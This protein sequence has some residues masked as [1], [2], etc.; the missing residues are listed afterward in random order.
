MKKLLFSLATILSLGFMVNSCD[1]AEFPETVTVSQDFITHAAEVSFTTDVSGANA[2]ATF[3]DLDNTNVRVSGP[4]AALIYNIDGVKSFIISG[5]KLQLILDPSANFTGGKEFKVNLEIVAAGYLKKIVPVTFTKEATASAYTVSMTKLSSLP[6]GVAVTTNNA[7]Q[8]V[9]AGLTAPVTVVS[10]VASNVDVTTTTV[11][12]PTGTVMRDANNTVL[13][14][15]LK[16]EVVSFTAKDDVTASFPGGLL[17]ENVVV[18]GNTPE[19]GLF[20]PVGFAS[21]EMTVGGQRVKAFTG[22]KVTLKMNLPKDSNNPAT[23]RPYAVGE[24]IDVFSYDTVSGQWKFEATAKVQ[25]ES[26]ESLFASYEATHL[27]WWAFG[28]FTRNS[29]CSSR[30]LTFN[31]PSTVPTLNVTLMI[32][33]RVGA[34]GSVY[35]F[36]M[37]SDINV[38]KNQTVTL[39]RLLTN[40][41]GRIRIFNSTTRAN[42]GTLVF[43]ANGLCGNPTINLNVPQPTTPVVNLSFRGTCPNN[44]T[45][46]LAPVGTYLNY[47][48]AGAPD[49]EY[50]LFHRVTAINKSVSTLQ[51]TLLT[52]GQSY[53][54]KIFVGTRTQVRTYAITPNT[55]VEVPI[56]Q[57]LCNE[58][59]Q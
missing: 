56:S 47:K 45:N 30:T 17:N 57:T 27:S 19:A 28:R 58:L 11:A 15:S 54:F 40:S 6:V 7:G 5:G 13:T 20:T 52:A 4:D 41:A 34:T 18:T 29:F 51:T 33:S 53:D 2:G 42:I 44:L 50:R 12:V 1:I 38:G 39:P 31:W 24:D 3:T 35:Q 55:L 32:E 49:S 37:G 46:V 43:A 23:D 26:N 14:G 25:K 48:T 8:V 22:Q 16:T 59:R 9:T 21:I 10:G 36:V